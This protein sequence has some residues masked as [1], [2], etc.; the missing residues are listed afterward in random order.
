MD[1]PTARSHIDLLLESSP[2]VTPYTREEPVRPP[3]PTAS[4]GKV[5]VVLSGGQDSTTCLFKAV[6][7]P[8][9]FDKV[10]AVSF[11]Y[12]QRHKRELDSAA[13][14]YELAYRQCAI[15]NQKHTPI[16]INMQ[17]FRYV[18]RMGPIFEG[19][20]PLTSDS[21]LEEYNDI[22]E[23]D[24]K[25]KDRVELTFVPGRN[26]VF[27]ALAYS[28]A[29][30]WGY[31]S[32]MMG[33]NGADNANYPDCTPDF[34]VGMTNAMALATRV[35]IKVYTPLQGM[36]KKEIVELGQ[37]TPGCMEA[38]AF[39]TTDYAGAYPPLKNHASVLRASG[40]AGAGT[41][42]PL[43]VRAAAEGLL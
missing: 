43:I 9:L 4:K 11:D 10:G 6:N 17:P 19:T 2:S 31:D 20:S 37:A 30:T 14:V 36:T 34:V 29:I 41:P 8:D 7:S 26:A 3:A 22:T 1:E 35:P 16:R 13:F 24:A 15:T 42:D 33:I 39:T 18:K 38:L 32:I 21:P 27:L 23:M 12:D 25:L 40:F 28:Y 5:L